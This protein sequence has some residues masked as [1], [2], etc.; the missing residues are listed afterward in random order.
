M[1]DKGDAEGKDAW[2]D[3]YNPSNI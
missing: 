1:A 3:K 2:K